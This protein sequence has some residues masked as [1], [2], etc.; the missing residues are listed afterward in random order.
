MKTKTA[1]FIMYIVIL[2]TLVILSGVFN[3]TKHTKIMSSANEP[4]KMTLINVKNRKTYQADQQGNFTFKAQ[5]DIGDR[6]KIKYDKSL[7]NI[8][9]TEERSVHTVKV[10]LKQNK[11]VKMV[12][13][14]SGDALSNSR[15]NVV[16]INPKQ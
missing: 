13:Y 3:P 15:E 10:N 12:M 11:P 5:V 14:A 6:L 16:I 9:V 4:A 2:G 7:A 8:K 1:S